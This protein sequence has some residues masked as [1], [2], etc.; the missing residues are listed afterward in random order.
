VFV[1]VSIWGGGTSRARFGLLGLD[2]CA[3]DSAGL[4]CVMGIIFICRIIRN[5]SIN[6]LIITV[7]AASMIPL[8]EWKE[9]LQ[10]KGLV[11]DIL[12]LTIFLFDVDS[13]CPLLPYM[14][15]LM[16]IPLKF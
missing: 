6:T 12:N 10:F 1:V 8:W 14:H 11:I 5:K 9:S 4:A 2:A 13:N 16:I 3:W 15:W 7:I